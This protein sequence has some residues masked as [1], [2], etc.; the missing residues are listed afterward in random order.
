MG[1]RKESVF[2][3]R[4]EATTTKTARMGSKVLAALVT[5]LVVVEA[6]RI[7]R[8]SGDCDKIT[9]EHQ[10]CVKVA[11]VNYV[12]THGAGD[13]GRGDWEA[14]KSCNYVN[15]AIGECGD[16]LG[17]CFGEEEVVARKD[18][19]VAAILKQ[20]ERD[21]GGWDSSKCPVVSEYLERQAGVDDDGEVVADVDEE[22]ADIEEEGAD[23]EEEAADVEEEA[24][25]IE[26]EGA[27]IEEE[28]ADIEEEAADIEEEAADAVQ[29]D[30]DDNGDVEEG[31]DAADGEAADDD[32][33]EDS[34]DDGD[35]QGSEEAN[36]DSEEAEEQGDDGDDDDE[37]ADEESEEDE[38]SSTM[39]MSS[40][41]LV[42]TCLLAA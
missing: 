25:D 1:S 33:Q 35:D 7:R 22:G 8:E 41:T 38:S 14:R 13:D 40:F 30:E 32:V 42:A 16:M 23:V 31:E 3:K 9:L 21:V 26:E 11:Y 36:E 37:D 39:M 28:G 12:A 18:H 15:V 19:Q 2:P 20:L 6:A 17:G 24:A 27:D 5:I 34:A 29:G 4:S 10:E